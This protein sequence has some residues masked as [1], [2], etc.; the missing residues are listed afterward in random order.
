[1]YILLVVIY[2]L[3]GQVEIHHSI[4]KGPQAAYECGKA[5]PLTV[6]LY[7]LGKFHDGP[8]PKDIKKITARCELSP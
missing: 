6:N 1:M 3:S 2:L 5:L 8:D 4:V 7:Q